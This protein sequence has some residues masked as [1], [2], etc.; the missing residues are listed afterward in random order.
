MTCGMPAWFDELTMR[1]TDG[2]TVLMVNPSKHEDR[3]L[4]P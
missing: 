3:E 4:D 2:S 1:T